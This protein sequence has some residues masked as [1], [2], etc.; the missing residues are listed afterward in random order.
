ME[1]KD[2]SN[3]K[4]HHA[5]FLPLPLQGHINPS[6]NFCLKLASSKNF[7]ITFLTFDFIHQQITQAR[8]VEG[9]DDIFSRAHSH[10]L[11]IRYRAISDG[12]PLEYDR[13]GK[14]EEYVGWYL[15]GAM[16]DQ[17]EKA[18]EEIVLNSRPKV[19][20]LII[21]TFYPW[22]SKIAKKFGLRFASFWTEPALV[23]N[24]YYHVHLLKQHGHF[25]CPDARKD[26]I[27]YIPGVKSIEPH[28]L[29]SYLQDEDISTNMHRLILQAYQDVR[30]AD[31]VL[32]NTVQELE[33]DTISTLQALMPFY[34]VGPNFPPLSPGNVMPTSLWAESNC[35][36]WLGSKA[37]GSVLYVSFGSL[38]NFTKDEVVEIAY[39][40]M[41][42]NID[43][44]WVLRP[45]TVLFDADQ[46]LPVGFEE[47]IRGR[48]IVVPWTNQMAVLSH[49]AIGG[50]LT[51]CGWNSVL[52][53]IWYGIPMLCFPVFSDQFTNRKLV[54]DD[55]KVGINLGSGKPL[56]RMEI[57][58]QIQRFMSKE[59]GDEL[60]ENISVVKKI[61]RNAL[62]VDGSSS[63][64]IDLFVEQLI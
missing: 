8:P 64:N 12:L 28:G 53:S 44:V 49:L 31:Y 3:K 1:A 9:F 2:S 10:G 40:L 18:V 16:F 15:D 57:A 24:L 13:T 34:A 55:W 33:S 63:K 25:D 36:E 26:P 42:S 19:D 41:L 39:G 22:A 56:R 6:V 46:L 47:V 51:H 61:L 48:G 4:T 32:C 43:F 59:T 29:M 7:T 35:S 54:V 50:F 21:D 17:V 30:S 52:E 27:D 45:R 58:T 14:V 62:E 38:A 60:R 5:I 20:M 37:N 23:F 11:D